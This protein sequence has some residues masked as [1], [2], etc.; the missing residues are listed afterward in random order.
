MSVELC[1]EAFG[2]LKNK[3]SML[4]VVPGA[5]HAMMM[6]KPFYKEFREAVLAFLQ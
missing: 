4:K 6:E 2:T 5:S 3:E 1:E